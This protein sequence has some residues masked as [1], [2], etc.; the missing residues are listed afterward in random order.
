MEKRIAKHKGYKNIYIHNDL[1]GAAYHY[2]RTIEDKLKANDRKGIAYDYIACMIMFAFLFEA[3][4]N[5]IGF[6]Q[7]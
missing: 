7:F 3:R 4:I 6:K 2:K 1:E 5:F